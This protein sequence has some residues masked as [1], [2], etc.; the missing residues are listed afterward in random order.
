MKSFIALEWRA[1]YNHRMKKLSLIIP[2]YNEQ[3]T[4]SQLLNKVETVDFGLEKEIVIVNDASTDGTAQILADLKKEKHYKILEN[5]KNVGKSQT[6]KKGILA[7]SGD[8]VVIQDADL[9]YDPTELVEFVKLFKTTNVDVVY[10]NRF[11]RNNKVIYLQNW[12]GNS[13]LSLVSAFFTGLRAKMWTRDME[14]CYKMAKGDIFRELAKSI[15]S[16]SNFGFEPEITAK[17]SKFR[18]ADGSRIAW[19]QLPITYFPRSIEEGKHMKAFKDGF[20]ALA[21]ILKFNLF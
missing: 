17:F 18:H 1:S 13:F 6:V 7:S 21:E 4:L 8:L 10:G 2:V 20:K 11:G 5:K 15:E 19:Q 9:E 16:K 12:L 14:V 3:A